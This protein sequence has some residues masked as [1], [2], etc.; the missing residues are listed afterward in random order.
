VEVAR[1]Y[2]DHLAPSW[3][4]WLRENFALNNH[5]LLTTFMSDGNPNPKHCSALFFNPSTNRSADGTGDA[6]RDAGG[7]ATPCCIVGV[8]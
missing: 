6:S 8:Y 1:R 3:L 2:F 5:G 4:E 7:V